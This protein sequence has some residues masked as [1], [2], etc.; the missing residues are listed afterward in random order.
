[1][2][3]L[4]QYRLLKK[5]KKMLDKPVNNEETYDVS[6][7]S[8]YI[9]DRSSRSE[10]YESN[11][12]HSLRRTQINEIASMLLQQ[13]SRMEPLLQRG[14]DAMDGNDN[15]VATDE[16]FI[17]IAVAFLQVDRAILFTEAEKVTQRQRAGEVRAKQGVALN[18][19]CDDND[20][21][22]LTKMQIEEWQRDTTQR[23]R[24]LARVETTIRDLGLNVNDI[25]C[26]QILSE[27]KRATAALE[28]AVSEG[29]RV[30]R[31]VYQMLQD[32][33]VVPEKVYVPDQVAY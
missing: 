29:A 22:T 30:C 27:R 31:H 8:M 15:S 28:A 24:K 7:S 12:N 17:D 33:Y 21:L 10:K 11:P 5:V 18:P 25:R 20:L 13:I 6:A 16:A 2:G 23:Q 19:M 3:K 32:L 9:G 14:R 1:M 26:T 4:A